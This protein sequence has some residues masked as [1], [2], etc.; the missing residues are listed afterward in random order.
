MRA[1][2]QMT[3]LRVCC[4]CSHTIPYLTIFV[5]HQIPRP[6]SIVG[7]LVPTFTF[8]PTHSFMDFVYAING[9]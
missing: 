1:V 8:P 9:A 7:R 6:T 2:G 3:L 4:C 5:S